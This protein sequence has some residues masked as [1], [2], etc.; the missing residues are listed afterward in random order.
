ML[1]TKL[2]TELL[3]LPFFLNSGFP[4][5]T[6]PSTRSPTHAAGNRFSLPLIP[7]TEIIYKLFAPVLSAQFI[8]AP[9]GRPKDTRNFA[10]DPPPPPVIQMSKEVKDINNKL[11][12]V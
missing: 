6:V 3:S 11:V 2:Q 9:T 7:L 1:I 12:E 10:P 8:T 4:F 5:F